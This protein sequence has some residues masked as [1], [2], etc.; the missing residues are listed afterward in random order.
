MV[1]KTDAR[2]GRPECP[3]C[4]TSSSYSF[5]VGRIKK[6]DAPYWRDGDRAQVEGAIELI[7]GYDRQE[8]LCLFLPLCFPHPPY[9]VAEP[10]FSMVDR[11][12]PP[13]RRPLPEDSPGKSTILSGMGA[14]GERGQGQKAALSIRRRMVS[15][16][17]IRAKEMLQSARYTLL[18]IA[19]WE[20]CHGHQIQSA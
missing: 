9:G 1:A 19:L 10:W 4:R 17:S 2:Q 15:C 14:R 11:D 5:F 18:D 20:S 3:S 13:P 7:R 6:G 16:A 12:R 8:P